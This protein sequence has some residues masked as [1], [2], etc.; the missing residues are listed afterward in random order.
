[1]ASVL[2]GI[3]SV[4]VDFLIE[5]PMV[6]QSSGVSTATYASPSELHKMLTQGFHA[7]NP[8]L[9]HSLASVALWK[10]GP[11]HC[12]FKQ[13]KG[14]KGYVNAFT[15]KKW[16]VFRKRV[17]FTPS[18]KI[19]CTEICHCT[20]TGHLESLSSQHSSPAFKLYVIKL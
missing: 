9:L 1:M 17:V 18:F 3:H 20:I 5:C 12:Y 10:L 16:K 14:K 2:G 15:T 6:L 19:L 4:F 13:D 7:G 11:T 8:A